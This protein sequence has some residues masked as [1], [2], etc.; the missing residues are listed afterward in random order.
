MRGDYRSWPGGQGELE[1]VE[2]QY[3]FGFRLSVAGEQQFAAIGGRQVEVDHLHGGELL[4]G[5]P[6]RAGQTL[7]R[8]RCQPAGR[9][10]WQP[11]PDDRGTQLTGRREAPVLDLGDH[12]LT[13]DRHRVP[14]GFA[15]H[16]L[17]A[18]PSP[19]CRT[20]PA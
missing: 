13:G 19:P 9:P 12:R 8:A 2:Q 4:D 5:A 1:L 18:I 6:W 14:L 20:V 10:W 15:V 7:S 17:H 3:E 16:R 11:A